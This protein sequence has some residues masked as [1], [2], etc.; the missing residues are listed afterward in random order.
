MILLYKQYE[1]NTGAYMDFIAHRKISADGTV[2]DQLL[3]QH[4]EAAAGYASDALSGIGLKDAG[5]LAGLLHDLGKFSEDFQLYLLGVSCKRRGS[6]IHTFQGC[7]YLLEQYHNSENAYQQLS[8]ELMAYAVGA[9]HGLFDCVDSEHKLGFRYRKEKE[10]I[11]YEEAVENFLSVCAGKETLDGLFRCAQEQLG[12]AISKLN[13]S[14][15]DD[16]EFAFAVGMLARLL[17][18][19]VIEGDRRDTAEF[20]SEARFPVWPADMRPIWQ[21]R[22][23]FLEE[24][25]CRFPSATPIAR[26]RQ[27]ISQ[28]CREAAEEPAGV[29]RLN[30]PTG[31][32]KTLASLRFALAHAAK[33]NKQRIIF[34]SPLL[35]ILEQNAKVIRDFVGDDSLI[36]EHH[37]NVVQTE[38]TGDALDERE[39]LTE[40]WSSPILLTT[41]VQL[42]NTLF[43]GKTTAI[44][45]FHALCDSVIVIDEVQTVPTKMLTLF[46]LAIRFLTE[47]CGATVVLC[48]AT[49]PCLE[50]AAHPIEN[51]PETIVPYDE[52]LW[53]PFRRTKIE[54]LGQLREEELPGLV[55]GLMEQTD[56]LLVICNKKDEAASL[57]RK[58]CTEPWQCFHLSAGMCMQHRRDTLKALMAALRS[59]QKT[60]CISTQVIEAGV[61]ISFQR[62]LRLAAGMD[63]VVQ[64]AG[65]CNRN[66]ELEE[67]QPVY[68]VNCSDEKLGSLR[69]I[70]Q[71][72]DATSALLDA[73]EKDPARFDGD[74]ASD[75]AIAY[76]YQQLYKE[77]KGGAQD[78]PLKGKT[79]V[80]DLLSL[81]EKNANDRCDNLEDYCLWQ[82]FKEAGQ[83]FQVF[84]TDTTDVLVPYGNGKRL[85]TEL[86]TEKALHDLA[87]RAG[88]LQEAKNYTASLYA[89]QKSK[90]EKASG[91]CLLG[92]DC[93][94]VL[95]DGFYDSRIGLTDEAY[96]N[97]FLEV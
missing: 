55:R 84:D 93:V 79:S 5:Y 30:V 35:S 51:E 61:D 71:A 66:G 97:E 85:I 80:Y 23:T 69:E 58:L 4:S 3:K 19:A 96:Q 7:R 39:L 36:L 31:G 54:P 83:A 11:A 91:L 82:A 74:L 37:S 65:R 40:N 42:L 63:S 47:I 76:Y 67:R 78:Y 43:S 6:V 70:Q 60:L 59:G 28:K 81:N 9:H 34:T 88:L 33:W 32:G 38:Q 22:L 73:Y 62:V 94:Y 10:N 21:A 2:Q 52:A 50:Q 95:L 45:R 72:K 64:S 41:L 17:L 25:L 14:Y 77:L 46:N 8:A 26:A 68:L 16:G 18:S 15:S 1:V 12:S 13:E 90:L 57:F 24:K 20:M 29:Y 56:S 86:C 44:R 87:Y 27:R 92:G 89:W 53:E 48:S 75:A 49:Q